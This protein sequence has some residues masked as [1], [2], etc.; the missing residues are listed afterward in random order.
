MIDIIIYLMYLVILASIGV[1]IW[2]VVR[3][4][5]M[6]GRT[7][8]KIHGIPARKINMTIV[9]SV[10]ASL[11]LSFAFADVS[12]IS[13]NTRLYDDMFWLRVSNM[14]VFTGSLFMLLGILAIIYSFMKTGN[15]KE[16]LMSFGI[17]TKKER[18]KTKQ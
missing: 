3:R 16:S 13:I 11:S 14:F 9:L 10:F 4:I 17:H 2:S 7:S 15:I 8:G 18:I 6:I 12:P 1:T 5:K